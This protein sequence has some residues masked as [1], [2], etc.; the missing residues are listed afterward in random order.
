[1][2]IVLFLIVGIVSFLAGRVST[3]SQPPNK[4]KTADETDRELEYL[5]NL[6]ESLLTE[7]Q[8]LRQSENNL[9]GQLW[10]AKQKLKT[11]QQKN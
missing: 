7:V 8:Q 1:M 11:L 3:P 6:N 2:D 5:Q 9:R 10:E 4:L